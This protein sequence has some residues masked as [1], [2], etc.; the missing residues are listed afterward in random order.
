MA[1]ETHGPGDLIPRPDPTTLTAAAVTVA[2]EDLRHDIAALRELLETKIDA[3]EAKLDQTWTLHQGDLVR[4]RAALDA[5]RELVMDKFHERD[6][7]F[8]EEARARQ[9]A[10]ET[11]LRTARELVD[12]KSEAN[13]EADN[14][15]QEAIVRQLAE[16]ARATA[17]SRDRMGEQIRAIEQRLVRGE[18][19]QTGTTQAHSDLRLNLGVMIAAIAMAVSV[20][21]GILLYV[22]K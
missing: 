11:A 22:K 1:D 8:S 21:L 5:L 19:T 18:G 14:K 17:D 13:Q 6:K 15:F 2:K 7:R 3:V 12:T 10:L 20:V 4:E 9:E 16:Q